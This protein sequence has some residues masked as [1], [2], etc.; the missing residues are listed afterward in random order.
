MDLLDGLN[1]PQRAAVT[2]T[3]GPVLIIAGPGSGKT[4][5]ITHRIAYLVDHRQVKPWR[6]LA[7]TFTNR[8]AREMRHRIEQLLATDL[9]YFTIGTFHATCARILRA[10]A[11]AIGVDRHFQIFDDADQQGLIKQAIEDLSLDSKRYPP[12]GIQSQISAAKS[13][14]LSP[15]AYRAHANTYY[16]EVAARV[17]GR[18]QDLLQ[19]GKGLDFDDLIMVTVNL[20]RDRP[21]V[22]ARYQEKFAYQMVDEFQDTNV[23]QYELTKLLASAHR[24]ICVVGDPDQSIYAWRHADIRNILNF[25]SD[26]PEARTIVL[27]QNYRSTQVI[28]D[29]AMSVIARNEERKEKE[30]WTDKE[31]GRP[32]Q[33]VVGRD[34]YEEAGFVAAEIERAHARGRPLS[35]FAVMYRTNAQSRPFE[36]VFV[37]YGI[38]YRLVGGT[39]FYERRE[40][41]DLLAY[42]RLIL[43]PADSASCQRILNVPPRSIGAK[44]IQEVGRWAAHADLPL[45]EAARALGDGSEASNV[46]ALSPGGRRLSAATINA[47]GRQA[48]ARFA[49]LVSDLIGESHHLTVSQLID[50]ILAKTDY[51]EY[52]EDGTQE[53]KERWDNV[54]ELRSVASGYDDLPPR[55]GLAQ[56]LDEAALV[57]DVDVLEQNPNAVTLITLHAAKGLEFPIVFIAG[58]EDSLLPHRR[59]FE[60]PT[61]LEEERRLFYVGVTRAGE[62]LYLTRADRRTVYGG[63]ITNPPSMFLADLPPKAYR[64]RRAGAGASPGRYVEAALPAVSSA[65]A[66]GSL[67]FAALARQ[68]QAT[69]QQVLIEGDRVRHE[70]FGE[71][72]VVSLREARGDTEVTVAFTGGTGVKRL[73]LALANLER[74][75]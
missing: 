57:A 55:E 73:L 12:R 5:V 46:V 54:Q 16:E 75:D 38:P 68:A 32:I 4:R 15:E 36:E 2:A 66:G 11:E 64:E 65:S 21:E 56:F 67:R 29:A 47:R 1:E 18:Y 71:G 19:R 8:A 26:F 62:E 43:N 58:L 17:Y 42:L 45:F 6:I 51:R 39:R 10:D 44:T 13:H 70:K 31:G 59:V 60:D 52:L 23:A 24:N 30:L 34:E 9:K 7:V 48:I 40:V 69:K 3:D 20:L 33:V 53:G 25:E 35:E 49:A 50:A 14:L 27:G 63:Q 61:Q 41:K 74:I 22:L 72:V 28:L 37:R